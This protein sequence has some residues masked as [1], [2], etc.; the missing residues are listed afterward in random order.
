MTLLSKRVAMRL[1]LFA[2]SLS[3]FTTNTSNA[4][5]LPFTVYTKNTQR[6]VS[7]EGPD[8]PIG[9]VVIANG[10]IYET[11]TNGAT[12]V[13]TFDLSAVTTSFSNTTERRQV[14]VE[15]SFDKS[16]IQKLNKS[17]VM[18]GT[19]KGYGIRNLAPT[20]DI[21]LMGVETYPIGGGI[22]TT[23]LTFG[24]SA[25]T[26]QF[27]G[28]EGSVNIAYDPVTQFFTYTFTLLAR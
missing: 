7:P 15:A 27:V 11:P 4:A 12:P 9:D 17:K 3:I 24:I 21:N 8:G 26:G 20:D 16:F 28:T 19:S 5:C 1:F 25:G 18:C 14:F 13:G 2:F 10:L 22:L 6:S 23:P